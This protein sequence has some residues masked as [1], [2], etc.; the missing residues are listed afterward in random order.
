M[1][2]DL[3]DILF[4][5]NAHDVKYLL[6]GGYAVG[7][8]TEPRTTKDLD[9]FVKSDAENS[10]KVFRALAEYGA[11]LD[12]MT[13]DDFNN[14]PGT[15][16]QIGTP[17]LRIDILQRITGVDFDEAWEGRIEGFLDGISTHVI[18]REHLIRNK[19]AV[20]RKQ[21]VLDVEN[22]REAASL[23]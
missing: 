2:K 10:P 20:G 23:L 22:I 8:Y 17:P 4:A 18:S 5:L 21:D 12:G 3:R 14:Q 7:V 9:V 13:S 11:P 19:L 16:F 1:D 6:V 15:V